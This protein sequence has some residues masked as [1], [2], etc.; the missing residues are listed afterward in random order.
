[1]SQL[2]RLLKKYLNRLNP[3]KGNALRLGAEF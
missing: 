1:M 3:L 2:E